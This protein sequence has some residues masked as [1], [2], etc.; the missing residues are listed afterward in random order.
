M[1]WNPKMGAQNYRVQV[2]TRPD[3]ATLV[4]S[5]TTDNTSWASLLTHPV[6]FAGG[7]FY[8]R[9]A[10]ADSVVANVGD[11]TANRSFTLPGSGTATKMSS[12]TT[13]SVRKTATRIKVTGTVFPGHA[14]KRVS[15][16]LYRK[17]S[18]V[19]RAVATKFPVLSTASSYAT[20][21]ARPRSGACK[22]TARFAGDADHYASSKA[23]KFRC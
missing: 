12:S 23:V 18:G 1:E 10:A 20:R 8:W 3:F 16:T 9:V 22:V 7:T 19:F 13:V 11:F 6:Y 5:I 14:G 21:F 15:V 17:R 4:E 2:S